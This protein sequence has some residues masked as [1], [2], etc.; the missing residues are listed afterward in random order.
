M[1]QPPGTVRYCCSRKRTG[2]DADAAGE[3]PGEVGGVLV[4][5]AAGDGGDGQVGGGEE[6]LGAAEP[7]AE[8]VVLGAAAGA[9][10][11]GGAQFGG[12]HAVPGGVFGDGQRQERVA[13]E[14]LEDRVA[15]G[16]DVGAGAAQG[17]E[18]F[19]DGGAGSRLR[20]AGCRGGPR[21][22]CGLTT[23]RGPVVS[24]SGT[25]GRSGSM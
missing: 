19:M 7:D 14:G 4:A 21:G 20:G 8:Q 18:E 2:A 22:R 11:D 10:A 25:R 16:G 5:D 1:D 13:G 24:L 6:F 12:G 17:D 23:A 9:A 3:Q 15:V